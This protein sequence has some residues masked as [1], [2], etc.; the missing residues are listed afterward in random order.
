MATSSISEAPS[1]VSPAAKRRWLVAGVLLLVVIAGFFDRISI[2]VLFTNS[3]FNQAIGIGF[4]PPML[5]LLMTSFLFAY[6]VSGV[7]L[8]FIGDIY[9]PRRSLAVGASL[10]GVFMVLIGAASSF[11]SMIVYR[12]LLGLAEGPQFALVNKV[13]KRWFPKHE[14]ARANSVWMVGSPLGSAIGFPLT[15]ALVAAFGWRSSFYALAILNIV[16]IVPLVLM[17]VRDWP[18]HREAEARAE[19][20]ST[21]SMTG[22]IGIFLKDWR[23]W[24]I[25]LFNSACLVY[26]WGLNAWLPSYLQKVQHFDLKS[27]GFF[28]S[29]P[30]ILMFFGE[31][32]GGYIS[33]RIGRR[34]IVCFVGLFMAG[35]LIYVVSYVSN[36]YAAAI[37]MA[38]S[39]GFWGSALPPLFAMAAQIIPPQVTASGVG[40]YNGAG[41]LIGACSPLLMGWIIGTAGNFDAGLL[42]LVGAGVLGSLA[43]LPLIKRY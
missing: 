15:I 16:I 42:V 3:E 43:M 13:V 19:E 37:V 2:A 22:S 10:W 38:L 28:A 32:L 11:T 9:G 41:N 26:L 7:L 40:V 27:L 5:G 23:F 4:N 17:L 1:A 12:V 18:P 34:A 6:G 31:L 8:S 24:M 25:L 14:Q 35:A 30:F 21:T 33:D 20:V 29:L 39:A 36:P